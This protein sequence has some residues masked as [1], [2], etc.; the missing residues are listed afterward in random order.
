MPSKLYQHSISIIKRNQHPSGAYLACPNFPPYRYSW[1]RDGAFIAYAMDM[2]DE[3][4]SANRFYEWTVKTILHYEAKI[5]RC[6]EKTRQN[7]VPAKTDFFHARFTPEGL[8]QEDGWGHHQLDGLGTW[9]W[10]MGQHIKM[11]GTS[12]IPDS[13]QLSIDLLQEYLTV[14]WPYPCYDC[15]EENQ[16]QIHTYTLATLFAGLREIASFTDN[17][18]AHNTANEIRSY[19]LKNAL[20]DGCLTKFIGSS[21]VDANLIGAAIP[22]QLLDID[23]DIMRETVDRI[24]KD[25]CSKS[26]GLHRYAQDTFYGGGSWILLT[27]WLGWYYAESGQVERARSILNWVENQAAPNGDLPEQI[28]QDLNSPSHF[29]IWVERW[30]DVASPLLWSHAMYLI[31]YRVIQRKTEGGN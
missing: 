29:S 19:V 22:C 5:H 12:A 14:L 13:W 30:G 28:S 3:H 23:N 4:E 1:F 21:E 20:H 7:I 27:A 9:L 26:G 2:V 18:T 24:E 11:C 25:L 15:W 31:L 17:H 10:S 6:I 16:D 8:E